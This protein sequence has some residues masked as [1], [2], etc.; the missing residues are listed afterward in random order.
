METADALPGDGC[1]ICGDDD[2]LCPG[3]PAFPARRN[4]LLAQGQ[5]RE[6]TT[7]EYMP[8]GR[9]RAATGQELIAR[10]E[11]PFRNDGSEGLNW[12]E[13]VVRDHTGLR[14]VLL[15]VTLGPR[16][17]VLLDDRR[18]GHQLQTRHQFFQSLLVSR[19]DAWIG[20]DA[21]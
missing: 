3:L 15:S 18:P 10:R 14:G 12:T 20:I 16:R 19:H 1:R 2:C 21:H 11:F 5:S 9:L 8:A 4:A 13:P 17:G 6:S 7:D